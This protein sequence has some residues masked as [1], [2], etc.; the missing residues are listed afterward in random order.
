VYSLLDIFH[1]IPPTLRHLRFVKFIVIL[2]HIPG[3]SKSVLKDEGGGGDNL[4]FSAKSL[5][6]KSVLNCSKK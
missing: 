6:P 1:L 4:K 5:N 2:T 3:N